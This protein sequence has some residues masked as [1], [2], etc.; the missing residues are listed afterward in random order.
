MGNIKSALLVG[1]L[2][3]FLCAV[4]AGDIIYLNTGGVIKGKIIK[5]D[6]DKLV[7][8]TPHGVTTVSTDDVDY[9]EEGGS[10]K[11]MYQ[12]RLKQIKDDDATA[13]YNLGV[14]LRNV[15]MYDEA[16]KEFEKVIK[17]DPNHD[18]ARCE[19]GYVRK[20][21]KWLTQEEYK[22]SE[23]YVKYEGKWV[24]KEEAEKLKTGFIKYRGEWVKKEELD[25]RKKGFRRLEGKWVSEDE[26]YKAKGYV[27]HDNKWVTPEKAEKLKKQEAEREAKRKALE[28]KKKQLEGKMLCWDAQVYVKQD[29][30]E[31]WLEKFAGRV[32]S[33]SAYLWK[34]TE[35]QA[36]ISTAVITDKCE[37]GNWWIQNLEENR[38]ETP[39]GTKAYA[40][41]DFRK[42][43]TGGTVD[44]YTVTHELGHLLFKL[45]DEYDGSKDGKCIMAGPKG[46]PKWCEDCWAKILQKYPKWKHPN[47]DFPA[48]PPETIIKIQNQ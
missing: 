22:K 43:V 32:K 8:R 3:L 41:C 17:I 29:V 5:R 28:Q 27:R 40:Y 18:Y 1:G 11:E 7:V 34:L 47:K 44:P 14:W 26:Y 45:R 46:A 23:G 16:K 13:H 36:Y 48:N 21:G 37:K 25:M 31:E 35:G 39:D 10:L 9:I 15:G 33:A 2:V 20:G 12:E 24:L 30:E 42:I 38:V 4:C 19:L 6:L